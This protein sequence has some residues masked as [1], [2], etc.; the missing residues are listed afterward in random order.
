[1]IDISNPLGRQ[2]IRYIDDVEEDDFSK[3]GQFY[4]VYFE[5]PNE[6]TDTLNLARTLF[7]L[8]EYRKA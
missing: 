2:G 4:K 3:K 1:M 8:R 7:D 6:V 5:K